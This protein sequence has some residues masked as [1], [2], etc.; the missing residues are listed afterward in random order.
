MF[1]SRIS[2]SVVALIAFAL[3]LRVAFLLLAGVHA[4]LTGDELAYQQIAENVA[5][6]R[7][8]YQTNNPFFP[9]Q[10]LYAWQA[11]LYPL[12]LGALYKIV[13]SNVLAAKWFGIVVSAA[14]VYVV[15]DLTRRVFCASWVAN[16]PDEKRAR[17]IALAASFLVAIYP[18]FLTLAHLLLSEGLFIFWL[19]LAFDFLARALE[20]GGGHKWLRLALAGAAWGLAT[21][22]RGLTLYFVPLL[23]LWLGWMLW[24]AQGSARDDHKGALVRG[25]TGALIFVMVTCAVIAPY[26]LRNYFQF[27]QW[28]LL[29]TKGGVNL[30]LGNS[31][32]TP[33]EFVRN[34]WKVGV[35]EPML[36]ALPQGELARDR[37]AYAL[38]L[39]Y[40]R[41]QPLAVL[42]RVP[43]KFADFWG[44]ERNLVDIAQATK[45]GGGWSA[46]SKIG[47]DVFAAVVY[48]FVMCAG[49]AGLVYACSDAWKLLFGG[50]IV[51][52]VLIHLA[53]FGDGRFH[54]PLIPFFAMYA[55]WMLVESKR[56][57][58]TFAR[59]AL[60][61]GGIG[62]LLAVW[63][64]EAWVAW[65]VL[66]AGL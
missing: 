36:N 2:L 29:E 23:A 37:A 59:N 35:R 21:L 8:L 49:V 60:A 40:M 63:W 62:L 4:P 9:G 25:I 54:L 16:E 32:Y 22:T 31:P 53:I 43:G 61:A 50:F 66:H 11:P 56:A 33:Y 42:A 44:F 10:L 39:E 3:V 12:A 52:F 38:A 5:A 26:T 28:V 34:V 65:N 45:E 15:Y 46:P 18:G 6:G 58:Y 57:Q 47:A 14:T 17:R 41:A 13:G 19:L 48:I 1:H 51:Y 24:R 55:G 27:H 7:G 20:K 30:W 64:R